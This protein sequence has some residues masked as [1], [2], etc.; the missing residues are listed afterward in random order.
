MRSTFQLAAVLATGAVLGAAAVQGV[1]AQARPSAYVVVAFNEIFD[2]A[3]LATVNKQAAPVVAAHGGQFVIRSP[4]PAQLSG[5][6]PKRFALI[7]FDS[8]DKARGWYNSADMKPISELR[9]KS[10]KASVFLVNGVSN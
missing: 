7:R 5:D 9:D 3:G 8:A 4:E 1:G 6:A 10:T 2:P